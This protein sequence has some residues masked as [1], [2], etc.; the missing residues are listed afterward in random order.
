[1]HMQTKSRIFDVKGIFIFLFI[2]CF[3]VMGFAHSPDLSSVMIYEQNG[4]HFL[5]IK[6]SLTAFEGEIDYHFNKNA[7]KTSEK[8]QELVTKYF[9][10][11]CSLIINNDTIKFI[12]TTV[13]LGHETTVFAELPNLPKKINALYLKNELFADLPHNQCELIIMI[14]GYPPKQHIIKKE[15]LYEVTLLI[16]NGRWSVIETVN[17]ISK[18]SKLIILGLLSIAA[19]IVLILVKRKKTVKS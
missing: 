16:E 15:N 19:I 7:Y 6:S 14:K 2:L 8:F 5:A 1:M 18:T 4:K 3:N 12:K 13:V 9:Q 10:N 11:K 17:P